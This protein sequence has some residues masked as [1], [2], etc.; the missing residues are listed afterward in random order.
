MAS[1]KSSKNSTSTSGP[2]GDVKAIIGKAIDTI[3]QRFGKGAIMALGGDPRPIAALDTVSTGSLNLDRAL[4]IGGLPRGRI[5]E[6]Y[7]PE[8]SGKTT[9]TLHA[10]AEAQRLGLVCAFV[11]AE[12]A[13]DAKY[14]KQ[15][16]VCLDDLLIAQPDYGEQ[17]LEIV[18]TLART[19]TIGMIVVDSVAALIPRAEL[20]GD[21]GDQHLGLQARLMSQAMR[22]VAGIAHQTNTLVVFINQLRHKIGVTFGSPET[23]TGGNALKYFASVRLDI[24][25]IATVKESETAVAARARVKVVKNKCAPP[26]ALAEFEIAFGRGIDREAEIL[27]WAL[28]AGEISKSGS[29]YGCGDQRIGQGR[30]AALEWLR[31]TPT[32]RDRLLAA[33]IGSPGE[34]EIAA[35]EA[36]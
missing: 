20:E 15:L 6:I 2:S 17:A 4:G 3:V 22:K 8:S 27:D 14:A 23:T 35:D 21:M 28:A 36:A 12:H 31:S 25:R 26:F 32:E 18:D 29:W 30:A 11:D 16:G 13:L 9:L 7:G 34:V 5:V 24:R 19:G 10:I 33:A 1:T